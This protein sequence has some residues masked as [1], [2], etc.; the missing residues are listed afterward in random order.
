MSQMRRA[1]VPLLAGVAV[2]AGLG[3]PILLASGSDG[4]SRH[5]ASVVTYEEWRSEPS[6]LPGAAVRRRAQE[7][8]ESF[9]GTSE[10]RDAD[11]FVHAYQSMGSMDVCMDDAGYPEFDWTLGRLPGVPVDPLIATQWFGAPFHNSLS[12]N[13]M[14]FRNFGLAEAWHNRDDATPDEQAAW[15]TCSQANSE[16]PSLGHTQTIGVRLLREWWRATAAYSPA[17]LPG[18]RVYE[19]CLVSARPIVL[20]FPGSD[21]S[22]MAMDGHWEDPVTDSRPGRTPRILGSGLTRSGSGS[23]PQAAV[24]RRR[25]RS[26]TRTRR[27]DALMDTNFMMMPFLE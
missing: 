2:I 25:L 4:Q 18:G 9:A 27:R 7:I 16:E 10:E 19:D 23:L 15:A 22:E 6:G 5:A 21:V 12:A 14:A 17:G 20:D 26:R 11:G 8:Y 3:A 13:E 1:A 24:P